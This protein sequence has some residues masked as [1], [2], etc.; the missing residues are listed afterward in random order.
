MRQY[1][2]L[3]QTFSGR[4]RA[5]SSEPTSGSHYQ[6]RRRLAVVLV[7]MLTAAGLSLFLWLE[8]GSQIALATAGGLLVGFILGIMFSML[9][10]FEE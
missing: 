2:A 1:V 3:V 6:I 7:G 10:R 8:L 4:R 9:W 5:M